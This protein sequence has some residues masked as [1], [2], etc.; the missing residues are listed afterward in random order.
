MESKEVRNWQ[1]EEALERYRMIL[2]LI[3]TEIDNAKRCMLREQI[4][5]REGISIRTIY[6]Y[7]RK[8]KESRFEGLV[9]KTREKRR[10]QKL[11][12][13][14]EEIVKEAVQLKREVPKRSIR[15][16]IFILESEGYAAPG[17][18]KSSTLQRYLQEAGMSKK[19][20]KR[21]TEDG[22]PSSKRF[23]KD[24]R[25]EL[26]QGDIKYGPIIRDKDGKQIK[27]YLSSVIDDHSRLI[28][29]SEWYDNQQSDIVED[30]VHKA[31]L[32]YGVFDRFYVDNGKQYVSKYLEKS[33]ARLGIRVLHTP[34]YSGK[35][36]GKVERFHQTVDRFSAELEVEHVH[37]IKEMNEKWKI[38]LEE[39]YQKKAHEGIAEYYRSRGVEVG[40]NGITPL[41][42]WNRDTRSLKY[43]DS[44]TV[45]E[46]FT[47]IETREIDKTGCF[48]FKGVKYEASAAYSGLKVEIVYDPLNTQTIDVRHGNLEVIHAHPLQ[49]GP[50]A[51]KEP[52]LPIGMTN[53]EVEGSR[54][55]DA[56]EKK[57]KES[58]KMMADAL[59]FGDYGKAGE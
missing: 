15:Q 37:S 41:Q 39:D 9:P 12:E 18:I 20:L 29:Q 40:K 58:H 24:H 42:E 4:A 48:E 7:E 47:R 51:S 44:G 55:L 46:A 19:A 43:L 36:K 11:P 59:S 5:E 22:K 10:S 52:A 56:L 21:Y 14:W 45:A 16:I 32:K 30:T 6:R 57:Y 8:Y 17:V 50:Y 27:T 35:S 3:D 2:P 28:L 38:F 13:N 49:I 26:Y 54:F 34:P 33:C 53:T 23:C 1:S 31:V 25:L